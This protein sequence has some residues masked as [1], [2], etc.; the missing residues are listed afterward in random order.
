MKRRRQD[1]AGV[2][3][4]CSHRRYSLSCFPYDI[5]D[6]EYS[7]EGIDDAEVIDANTTRLKNDGRI[8][9]LNIKTNLQPRV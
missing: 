6:D 2:C 5:H 1:D 8:R 9:R 4:K 7:D 3:G